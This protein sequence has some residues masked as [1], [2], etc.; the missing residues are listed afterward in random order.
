[1]GTIDRISSDENWYDEW[2]E[3]W[4]NESYSFERG[5]EY[6]MTS[7][8]LEKIKRA[9]DEEEVD[10]QE[11]LNSYHPSQLQKELNELKEERKKLKK[12]VDKASK[13]S[14]NIELDED[15][16]AKKVSRA[17]SKFSDWH[18]VL[19]RFTY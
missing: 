9:T 3:P 13:K 18:W 6:K 5:V 11:K 7:T 14:N 17:A 12:E 15:K 4:D 2:N 10:K 16:A 8:G 1:M 19:D